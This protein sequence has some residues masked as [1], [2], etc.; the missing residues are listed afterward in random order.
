M[1]HLTRL[2]TTEGRN[3]VSEGLDQLTT[4]EVLRVMN[5][6]DHRVPDAVARQ[7]PAIAAIV[8]A[9][10][11]GLSAGG[12]LIYAGAGTSGRLGV[13]DAA[14][15]PPTFS[16]HPTMVVGLIA[17]GQQ[18]MFQAVEGAEDDQERGAEEINALHPGLHDVVVGLAASGRTPWVIGAV[19]AAKQA[20][21]H[22]ASVCCNHDALISDEVDLPVEIDAGPEVL[23]GSTR[24]KAGTAQKLVLNMISTATMVGL[25]KTY[26]NLMVDV[27]PSNEKLRQRAVSIVVSAT[28]CTRDQAVIAL[29]EADGHAKTAIVMILLDMTAAQAR[30]RLTTSGGAVRAAVDED[31]P[32]N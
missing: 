23:T 8:E 2:T 5:D 9:A 22:T 28:G 25:G 32:H 29:H 17:G 7:L 12:R 18:A 24:L 3:P 31:H 26:G 4:L 20:G 27:S 16:T 15:C 1:D 30:E 21:A 10:V 19:R 13:L 6:E 11:A 14:E